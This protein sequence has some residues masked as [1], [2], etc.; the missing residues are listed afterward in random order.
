MS[1]APASE[2]EQ[3]QVDIRIVIHFM[4]GFTE[5]ELGLVLRSLAS[6]PVAASKDMHET[7]CLVALM[8]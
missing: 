2:A 5:V 1:R 7:L 4:F 6:N 8:A 3:G